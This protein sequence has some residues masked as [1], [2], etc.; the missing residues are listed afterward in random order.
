MKLNIHSSM[1]LKRL[2]RRLD[3]TWWMARSSSTIPEQNWENRFDLQLQ[4]F[5]KTKSVKDTTTKLFVFNKK[6]KSISFRSLLN[7]SEGLF[8]EISTS[9]R[10]WDRCV[11]TQ[12]KSQRQRRKPIQAW[13]V[14]QACILVWTYSTP[15]INQAHNTSQFCNNSVNLWSKL[16][17][18]LLITLLHQGF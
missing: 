4:E 2:R 8:S 5:I 13:V 1:P 9:W 15:A 11:H 18:E 14:P 12:E 16:S 7:A 17:F 10:Y 3:F 6:K